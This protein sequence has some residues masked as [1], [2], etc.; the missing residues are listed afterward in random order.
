M[1]RDK[2]SVE[3]WKRRN[4]E[5]QKIYSQPELKEELLRNERERWRNRMKKG[6]IKNIT[7]L[8]EREKRYKRRFW[9]QAQKESRVHKNKAQEGKHLDTPLQSPLDISFEEPR[10][11]R[12]LVA[13]ERERHSREIKALKD[14]LDKLTKDRDKLRK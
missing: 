13:G 11:S 7:D 4:R 8:V 12:Q 2:L 6:K 9:K 5:Y 14:K 1:A 3:E 10:S